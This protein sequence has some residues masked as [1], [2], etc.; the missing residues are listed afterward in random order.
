MAALFGKV[1]IRARMKERERHPSF[2]REGGGVGYS[3]PSFFSAGQKG[4]ERRGGR[5]RNVELGVKRRVGEG[6]VKG[7]TGQL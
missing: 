5:V 3:P 7:G 1:D 2:G 4:E 6:G